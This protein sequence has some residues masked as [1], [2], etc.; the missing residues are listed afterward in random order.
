MSS[1]TAG[2]CQCADVEEPPRHKDRRLETIVNEHLMLCQAYAHRAVLL[3]RL[4]CA[5][6]QV[7]ERRGRGE[8]VSF[9][10]KPARREIRGTARLDEVLVACTRRVAPGRRPAAEDAVN[11][12]RLPRSIGPCAASF[13]ARRDSRGGEARGQ[14]LQRRRTGS[15]RAEHRT[16]L[17]AV[18]CRRYT[19]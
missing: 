7:G 12:F 9:T 19:H 13:A 16:I 2:R 4:G 15:V 5:A 1:G 14:Q 11:R 8:L 18:V 6:W 17:D 3:P 10:V